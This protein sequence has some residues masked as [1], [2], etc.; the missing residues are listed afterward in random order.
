VAVDIYYGGQKKVYKVWLRHQSDTLIFPLQEKSDLVN[1]DAE[2][3]LL[4]KKT[5]YKTLAEF[6]F[7]YVHG[8][9]YADRSEA[10]DA[11]AAEQ[12]DSIALYTLISALND[13]Y[14][15]LRI[16]AMQLLDLSN[17]NIRSAAAP[18]LLLFKKAK[19]L[20]KRYGVYLH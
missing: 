17:K 12:T 4:A 13:R 2:K 9:L 14:Y 11:A 15:G 8:P 5:D 7:Q 10:V 1:V 19:E 18:M 3:V 20:S 6:A 16:K